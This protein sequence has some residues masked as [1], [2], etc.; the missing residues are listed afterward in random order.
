MK[1]NAVLSLLFVIMASWLV[2]Y[3]AESS[4]IVGSIDLA[5]YAPRPPVVSQRYSGQPGGT[6]A[7]PAPPHVAVVYLE[8]ATITRESLKPSSQPIVLEQRGLQFVPGVLPI[9]IGSKVQFPN[10]DDVYHN[11]FSYSPAKSFDLGRYSKSEE[12]PVQIFDTPGLV[13]LFCEVHSHM[14]GAI[15]VLETPYFTTSDPKGNFRFDEVPAGDYV[16]KAWVN[17]KQTLE[18]PISVK[19]GETLSVSFGNN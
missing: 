14:R 5:K 18:R 11:V 10:N 9:M 2:P 1:S 6:K 12:A 19:E 7:D 4:V 16:L 17:E 15:L 3:S 13:K 8:G